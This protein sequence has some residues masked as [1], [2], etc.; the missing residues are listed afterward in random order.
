MSKI[1]SNNRV[2]LEAFTDNKE[3]SSYYNGEEDKKE[4]PGSRNKQLMSSNENQ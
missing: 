2:D 3:A 4:K 1:I